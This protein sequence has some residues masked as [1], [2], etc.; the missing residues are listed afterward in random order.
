MII[1]KISVPCTIAFQKTHPFK[2][3]L[4]EIPIYVEVSSHKFLDII[5]RNCVY[6]ILSDEI[7]I[8]FIS[9]LKDITLQHYMEQPRSMLC[10]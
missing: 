9:N 3:I 7:N 2:P 5:D 10:R 8:I 4:A 6:N 1:N